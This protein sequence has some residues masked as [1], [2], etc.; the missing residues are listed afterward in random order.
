MQAQFISELLLA[1]V[2]HGSEDISAI[3]NRIST[4]TMCTPHWGRE[5]ADLTALITLRLLIIVDTD[6]CVLAQ[7]VHQPRQIHT[8][9]GYGMLSMHLLSVVSDEGFYTTADSIS[10]ST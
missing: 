8:G 6:M 10:G 5:K 4:I 3:Y 9:G 2:W 1:R 7:L